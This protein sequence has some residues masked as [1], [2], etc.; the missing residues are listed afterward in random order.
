MT[1]TIY[2]PTST[3]KTNLAIKL[4]KKLNGEI[5]SADSRQVYKNLDIGSGKVSFDSKVEKHKNF[6]LVD[7]VKIN[8]FDLKDPGEQFTAFDF[9]E[10]AN[11]SINKITQ[12]GKL[13]IVVGGSA[14]Y[15]KT[16]VDGIKSF[17]IPKDKNLRNKLEKMSREEL[18][19][20]LLKLDENRALSMNDSDEKNP[21]RLIRAIEINQ[22]ENKGTTH[23]PLPTTHYQLIGLTAPNSFLFKKIDKW[24]LERL[25]NGLEEEVSNLIKNNVDPTWLESLGLEYRWIT[26][27]LLGKIDKETGVQ[28]LRGDIHNYAKRQKTWFK[29][30]ND[31]KIVDVSSKNWELEL[32]KYIE[33]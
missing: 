18:Y 31:I 25:E 6:W 21:R 2:G 30:F 7:G 26:R 14:F 16:L 17:G 32:D 23:Y 12:Q 29:K 1:L 11:R 9:V 13:P 5:I 15:I 24:L 8:G 19:E 22:S 27:I 20:I 28:R 10:F 3:G 33:N 4:A